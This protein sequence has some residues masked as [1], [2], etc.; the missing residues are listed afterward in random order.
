M[1]VCAICTYPLEARWT[2]AP[3]GIVISMRVA[4]A[5]FSA[6]MDKAANLLCITRLAGQAASMGAELVVFPEGSMCDF[7]I[8][9]HDL[10]GLAEPMDGAF[11]EGVRRLATGLGVTVVAGMFETIAGDQRI[12]NT[13]VVVDPQGAVMA[14]YR[15]RNLFDAFG[16]R[17][18]AR[19]RPGDGDLPLVELHGFEVALAICYDVRFPGFISAAADRGAE[20]LVLPSAW[21]AGPLKEDHW[22]LMVR[23]RAMENTMYVAAAGQTGAKYC[24]RSMVVDPLGVVVAG[25]IGRAHV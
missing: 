19:F 24:G 16:D 25:Q 6:G 8:A 3:G 9:T 20:L 18:S 22:N 23:A 17:E 7:G 21:V 12:Y 13:A 11:V 2:D 10:R 15:K 4:V 14:A 1:E 5:Q